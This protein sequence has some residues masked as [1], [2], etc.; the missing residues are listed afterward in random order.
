MHV[1]NVATVALTLAG[2]GFLAIG[3][4]RICYHQSDI[5]RLLAT[6]LL[7][8]AVPTIVILAT[9]AELAGRQ[10]LVTLMLALLLAVP[11]YL[12]IVAA[13]GANR[14]PLHGVS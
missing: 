1:R 9:V 2:A 10:L 7:L 13:T 14:C 11:V 5:V 12:W 8:I 3:G 6:G 4:W